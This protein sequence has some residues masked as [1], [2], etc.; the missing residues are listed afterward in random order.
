MDLSSAGSKEKQSFYI[1]AY[2]LTVIKAVVDNYPIDSPM[3][4]SGF[5]DA[6]K[7]SMAGESL[8][9]K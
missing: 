1:N 4:V 3:D 9:I 6:K 8:D 7:Y 2:N 5:F